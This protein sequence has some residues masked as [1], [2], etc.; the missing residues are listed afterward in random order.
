MVQ[1]IFLARSVGRALVP[2]AS[3]EEEGIDVAQERGLI[4]F[5]QLGDLSDSLQELGGLRVERLTRSFEMN[6]KVAIEL[7]FSS[8][9][10]KELAQFFDV[11]DPRG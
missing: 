9:A 2:S 7:R 8:A 10:M 6:G 5:E 1:A 3:F 11:F 4:A